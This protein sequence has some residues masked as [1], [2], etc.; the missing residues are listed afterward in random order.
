MHMGEPSRFLDEI[1]EQFISS[2]TVGGAMKKAYGTGGGF[3]PGGWGASKSTSK[4]KPAASAPPKPKS[5]YRPS[6]MGRNLKK[7]DRKSTPSNAP[8]SDL[9]GLKEGVNVKHAKFGKGTVISIEGNSPNVK[10]TI[11]FL[12]VGTKQLLLKFAKLEI[13]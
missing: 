13:L 11:K 8:A 9:S 6:I 10:A 7:V 5:S 4:P 12:A 3:T 2:P 1:D